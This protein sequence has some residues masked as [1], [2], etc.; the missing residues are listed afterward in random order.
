MSYEDI[1]KS[2]AALKEHFIYPMIETIKDTTPNFTDAKSLIMTFLKSNK[3]KYK[4]FLM[5][6]GAKDIVSPPPVEERHYRPII[7]STPRAQQQA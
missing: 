1:R 6:N 5:S 7:S 3:N 2:E 4:K